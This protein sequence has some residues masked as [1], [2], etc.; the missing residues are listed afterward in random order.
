MQARRSLDPYH[1]LGDREGLIRS[2]D[3]DS[4]AG[5]DLAELSESGSEILSNEGKDG[6][7]FANGHTANG[8]AHDVLAKTF[9]GK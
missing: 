3:L 9:D 6:H 2:F 7:A 4:E 8:N 1:G 5:L